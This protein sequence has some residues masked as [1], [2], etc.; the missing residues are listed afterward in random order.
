MNRSGPT[1]PTA[2]GPADRG[3]RALVEVAE[4]APAAAPEDLLGD[5]AA[6]LHRRRRRHRELACRA[7]RAPTAASPIANAPSTPGT[8]RNG[9]TLMRCARVC[10]AG[11]SAASVAG[12]HARGPDHRRGLDL[13]A[14]LRPDELV[15][16][17]RRRARSVRT[18]TPRRSSSSRA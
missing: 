15:G 13:A 17:R 12:L 4:R 1:S 6:L 9:S 5:V 8:R 14:V 11:A 10:G 18:S 16:R 3:Q 7:C 2:D